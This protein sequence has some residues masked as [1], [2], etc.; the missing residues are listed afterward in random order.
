M[1]VAGQVEDMSSLGS[2]RVRV[3]RFSLCSEEPQRD[4]GQLAACG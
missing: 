1:T 3:V 4:N 2:L